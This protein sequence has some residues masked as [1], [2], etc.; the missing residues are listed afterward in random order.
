MREEY[1]SRSSRDFR[2]RYEGT[3]GMFTHPETKK[4]TL[5]YLTSV[6]DETL[7]FQDKAATQF[8][9]KA[10][11]GV[12]FEFIPVSKK[13][14]KQG[15]DLLF[16][17]RRPQRQFQRGLSNGNASIT[18]LLTG[19]ELDF[20]FARVEALYSAEIPDV[21]KQLKELAAGETS[22]AIFSDMFGITGN[23]LWLYNIRI[24]TFEG[25]R[26]VLNDATFRQELVD[27]FMSHS[28]PYSVEI[29]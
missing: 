16:I 27:C 4:K 28:L 2:Q 18:N 26:A 9:A 8:T 3:Y 25:G 12:E 13:I 10:D 21:H 23:T 5:V 22:C 7:T 19:R 1:Q 17:R 20:S 11:V 29:A 14:F 15:K 6:R 24:G